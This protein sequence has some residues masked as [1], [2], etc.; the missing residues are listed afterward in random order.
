MFNT[1]RRATSREKSPWET[2]RG[3]GYTAGCLILAA[4][5]FIVSAIAQSPAATPERILNIAAFDAKGQP[6]TDLT[7]ADF[8]IFDNGKLQPIASFTA[9]TARPVT[10]IVF[11]L[12]NSI[13]ERRD[14][15]SKLLIHA[16]EPM[17]AGD[18][19][20]L[21]ILSN[22]GAV[23]SVGA[24]PGPQPT[25]LRPNDASR[26]EQPANAPWTRQVRPLLERAI[27]NVSAQRIMEYADLGVDSAV[28]FRF[29]DELVDE[30]TRIP[31]PRAIIWITAGAQNRPIYSHGCKD[32]PFTAGSENYT[33]GACTSDCNGSINKCVSYAPFLAH[34][35]AALGKSGTSLDTVQETPE[36]VVPV[37][38]S[39]GAVDTLRQLSDL[40]GGPV[41]TDSETEKAIAHAQGS[42]GRY[43]LGYN[44]PPSDGKAHKI[45]VVCGRKGVLIESPRSR[46]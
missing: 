20:Y 5:A 15:E 8:Q 16:L 1:M 44:A 26:I 40:T 10:V 27:Q 9:S 39:G 45:R 43:Q 46:I 36:G 12:L 35:T 14:Y 17:E 6:V 21:D 23:Y 42:S 3:K 34:F 2:R 29:F 4:S 18:S 11:D 37:P 38:V 24:P 31:G 19:V 22:Q 7:G 25:L 41:Y 32:V 33:G 13:P 30:L 28:T